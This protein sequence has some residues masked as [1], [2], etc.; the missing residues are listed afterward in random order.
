MSNTI[1]QGVS[2]GGLSPPALHLVTCLGYL[3]IFKAGYFFSQKYCL[4]L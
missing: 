2:A 4:S 3:Q 1:F